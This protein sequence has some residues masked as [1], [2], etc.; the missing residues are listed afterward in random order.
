MVCYLSSI[1]QITNNGPRVPTRHYQN[2]YKF[3]NSKCVQ[4]VKNNKNKKRAI[5]IF[6][7]LTCLSHCNELINLIFQ[8]KNSSHA[9]DTYWQRG[10][11]EN[12]RLHS[13]TWRN[14][15][16]FHF[17]SASL[18]WDKIFKF[19]PGVNLQ[20]GRNRLI[21]RALLKQYNKRRSKAIFTH[22]WLFSAPFFTLLK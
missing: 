8:N 16:F 3:C 11:Y 1:T 22:Q 17:V 15:Y 21:K 2:E 9:L 19:L 5:Q 7:R 13:K 20:V 18:F 12:F 6:P 14:N 10:E 4:R